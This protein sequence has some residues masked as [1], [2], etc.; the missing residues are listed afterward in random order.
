[1][2][3]IRMDP[4]LLA[5]CAGELGA[6]GDEMNAVGDKLDAVS[7][8]EQAFGRLGRDLGAPEAY[9]RVSK[10]VMER[11]RRTADVVARAGDQLRDVVEFHTVGDEDSAVEFSR[12]Q[13][14]W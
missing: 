8:G 6:A 11:T 10:L 2:A 3:G 7:L 4:E 9:R 5:R 13:E 1:M 14:R 12:Q